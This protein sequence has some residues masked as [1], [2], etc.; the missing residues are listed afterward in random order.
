MDTWSRQG[1]V[2][3]ECLPSLGMEST[4][5]MG[6]VMQC[7]GHRSLPQG[8]DLCVNEVGALSQESSSSLLHGHLHSA[9]MPVTLY[10]SLVPPR[11]S[12][13]R[14]WPDSAL[15]R[16]CSRAGCGTVS[17][18]TSTSMLMPSLQTNTD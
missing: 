2:H 18:A 13:E 3:G 9:G 6:L 12:P 10:L 4:Q 5:F 8:M 7:R 15:H 11:E 16:L 17:I 1:R 14:L